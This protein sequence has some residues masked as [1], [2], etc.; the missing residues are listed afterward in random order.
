M[1]LAA[2]ANSPQVS[3]HLSKQEYLKVKKGSD[4]LLMNG[5]M[6]DLRSVV[7]NSD[8]IDIVAI[9]DVEEDDII[10]KMEK[11]LKQGSGDKRSSDQLI[12]LLSLFYVGSSCHISYFC[13]QQQPL[14]FGCM[15]S[16]VLDAFFAVSAPPPRVI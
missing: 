2:T 4:E 8:T 9:C 15:H 16:N 12:E 7:H 10:S 11:L 5:K 6:Y 3:F 1:E 14:L 13:Y